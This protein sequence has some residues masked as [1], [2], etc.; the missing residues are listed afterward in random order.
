M[1]KSRIC[2]WI[3][4]ALILIMLILQ[5]TPFWTYETEDGS[6]SCSINGYV[7]M[8]DCHADTTEY[9][10][11]ALGDSSFSVNNV[12]AF[13]A[14]QLAFLLVGL[15]FCLIK[16]DTPV[17]PLAGIAAGAFGAAGYMTR[18]ALRLG[19]AWSLHLLVSVA[20]IL[21]GVVAIVA[22]AREDA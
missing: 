10:Q 6:A 17:G 21:M 19:S 1:S 5:F 22:K 13:P 18:T 9:L 12:Y 14:A 7:W 20:I 2:T 11:S 15:A 16:P 4:A 8:P 3:C